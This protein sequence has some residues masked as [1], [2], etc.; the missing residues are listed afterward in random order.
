MVLG[1]YLGEK[2]GFCCYSETQETGFLF[3]LMVLGVY[4]G[5]KPGFWLPLL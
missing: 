1:V 5:E 3:K 4:L 2:P